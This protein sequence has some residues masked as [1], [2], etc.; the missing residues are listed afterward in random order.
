[1][2]ATSFTQKDTYIS[3]LIA[4]DSI[5][6]RRLIRDIFSDSPAIKISGEAKTGIEALD[7]VLKIRPDVILMDMEMPLMDGMTALQHLMIHCPTPTIMLSSLTPEG[8][9]RSFD[10]LKNGAVDFIGKVHMFEEAEFNIFKKI[11]NRKVLNASQMKIHSIEPDITTQNDETSKKNLNRVVFCEDCGGRNIVKNSLT[12]SETVCKYCGDVIELSSID[13]YRRNSFMT[14]LGGGRDSFRNL[15][16]IVPKFEAELA[17]SLFAVV[18]SGEDQ[19]KAFCEY[20]DAISHLKVLRAR[21]GMN[22]EAGYCYI[23]STHDNLCLKPISTQFTFYRETRLE[24]GIGAIDMAMSSVAMIFKNR[25]AGVLL[26]SNENDGLHGIASVINNSGNPIL[27][28]PANCLAPNLVENAMKTF[29][30]VHVIDS[31]TELVD[32]IRL[33]YKKAQQ[34]STF[35]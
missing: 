18:D 15:L 25:S 8:T 12:T 2:V 29:S 1:M 23:A 31:E 32:Y 35:F 30:K 13:R 28:D 17:G 3:V 19:L 27:I 6:F 26:A 33:L 9:T 20:L 10:A 14:V 11:I 21:S 34:G 16:N 22:V 24:A 7:M 4:D 5:V